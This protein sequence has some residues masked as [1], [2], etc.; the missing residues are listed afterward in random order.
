[1]EMPLW[2][3]YQMDGAA[4]FGAA[5]WDG[6]S[7]DLAFG[8]GAVTRGEVECDNGTPGSGAAVFGG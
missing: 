4:A 8:P 7:G 1:L 3:P 2:D 6:V 5:E